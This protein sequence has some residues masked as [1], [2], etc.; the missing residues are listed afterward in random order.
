MI[1]LQYHPMNGVTE[2]SGAANVA[3]V[4]SAVDARTANR[5]RI[6]KRETA[7]FPRIEIWP[8]R[9]SVD[10]VKLLEEAVATEMRARGFRVGAG[11][12][13]VRLDL[14]TFFHRPKTHA[15]TVTSNGEV[16]FRARVFDAGSSVV[17][18]KTVLGCGSKTVG[19]ANMKLIG[20]LLEEGL[21]QAVA[22]LMSDPAFTGAVLKSA[23]KAA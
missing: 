10:V 22:S 1:K 20:R 5:D 13:Q 18:D 4:V 14:T 3:L 8:L 6:S 7:F 15:F 17:Y 2:V 12:A 19:F 21:A 11:A 23:A 16:S 9:S